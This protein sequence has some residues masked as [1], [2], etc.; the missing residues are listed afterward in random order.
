MPIQLLSQ[1][2]SAFFGLDPSNREELLLE[3]FYLL[4]QHLKGGMDWN[5]YVGFYVS[6]RKWLLQR[7]AKDLEEQAKQVKERQQ[8]QQLVHNGQA[9]SIPGSGPRKF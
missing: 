7:I 1:W 6:Y 5:T 4:N 2:M 3:P 8:G 9:A